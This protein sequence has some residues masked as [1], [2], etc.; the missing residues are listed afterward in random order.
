[1][2]RLDISPRGATP[3]GHKTFIYYTAL[4]HED[5]LHSDL[6]STFVAH[7]QEDVSDQWRDGT[8]LRGTLHPGDHG[9]VG[10]Q[11]QG[12]Q[13]AFHIQQDPFLVRVTRHSL[14]HQ[15]PGNGI[16]E[17]FYIKVN[18][19]IL[20]E[21]PLPAHPYR[22]FRGTPRTV[23]V[24]VVVEHLFRVRLQHEHRHRLRYP[25]HHVRDT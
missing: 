18:D 19:P 13:P 25:I 22:V 10:H 4:P 17:G 8:P 9:P 20:L 2:R 23:P 21:T 15:L 5:R 24:R 1:M 16:E 14:E 7:M 12:L 3:K 6:R 11:H